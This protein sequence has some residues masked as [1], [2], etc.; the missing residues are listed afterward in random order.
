MAPSYVSLQPGDPAPWFHQAS[1]SNPRYAFDSVGGR[2]VVFCFLGS[3]SDP[4]ARAALAVVEA[5]RRQF[6]D[7]RA[8]FFGVTIDPEDQRLG[9]LVESMPGIRFF[10]DFDRL[11]SGRYGATAR[12]IEPGST[13]RIDVRQFWLLLDPFLR[14]MA[15][16]PIDQGSAM[17]DYLSALPPPERHLGYETQAPILIL[18]RVFEPEFCRRLIEAHEQA[19]GGTQ[20]GFMREEGGKTIEKRDLAFKSRRDHFVEDAETVKQ[21][22]ARITRRVTPEIAKV[23]GVN[24]TRMERYLVGCYSQEEGGHFRPHRDNTTKGTAHRRFALSINLNDAFDGGELGFP[25]FGPRSF[26]APVGAALIFPGAL[27]HTVSPVT[28]G[29]RYAFLP[30]V[31]DEAAARIREENAKFIEGDASTYKASAAS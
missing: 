29:R 28:R 17:A 14:V 31:Y 24:C 25:E 16:F 7:V 20:S 9:R 11:V 21:I 4:R 1:T 2:Y 10:W 12:D 13:E 27:L 8:C 6:D 22:Q 23:Y 18:P 3:A 15:T 5:N 30:F 19:G 26:K